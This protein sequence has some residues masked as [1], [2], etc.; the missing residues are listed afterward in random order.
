MEDR[1]QVAVEDQEVVDQ[2]AAAAYPAETCW[3]DCPVSEEWAA[4]GSAGKRLI[5]PEGVV[6]RREVVESL[7]DQYANRVWARR[8][9]EE[10]RTNFGSHDG[11]SSS[12]VASTANSVAG[13]GIWNWHPKRGGRPCS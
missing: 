6:E 4:W 9:R 2:V 1:D 7:F 13:N 8:E 3:A 11:P 5:L 10:R 12:L